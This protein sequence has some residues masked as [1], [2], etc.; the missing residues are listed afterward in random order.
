VTDLKSECFLLFYAPEFAL[1]RRSDQIA[2]ILDERVLVFLVSP[3]KA[4]I[5]KRLVSSFEDL[6]D[7]VNN[8]A[9]INAR[10]LLK[11]TGVRSVSEIASLDVLK[12][13]DQ[14]TFK[15]ASPV[16]IWRF[17]EVGTIVRLVEP[18]TP[19][20]A[21][22]AELKTGV[23][24]CC[25]KDDRKSRAHKSPTA[26]RFEFVIGCL[27]ESSTLQLHYCSSGCKLDKYG[28][29]YCENPPSP[30]KHVIDHKPKPKDAQKTEVQVGSFV[31][32]L[33]QK[34][35][36][37]P[38]RP[39][40]V[41]PPVEPSVKASKTDSGKRGRE[42]LNNDD[43]L[44]EEVKGRIATLKGLIEEL[45]AVVGQ[46]YS[47]ERL[48]EIRAV[49]NDTTVEDRLGDIAYW[50]RKLVEGEEMLP[51]QVVALIFDDGLRA[52]K[53]PP[54]DSKIFAW[55]VV[56]DREGVTGGPKPI[57]IGDPDAV[58]MNENAVLVVY[59]G[60][61]KVWVVENI[62]SGDVLFASE[63][64]DG[65]A[66]KDSV[67]GRV[68]VALTNSAPED[69]SVIA[70]VWLM[71]GGPAG[72][73]ELLALPKEVK[74]LSVYVSSQGE[75]ITLQAELLTEL[76]SRVE[77]LESEL[78]DIKIAVEENNE[79]V[80]ALEMRQDMTEQ[81]VDAHEDKIITVE[82]RLESQVVELEVLERGL[83]GVQHEVEKHDEVLHE[84]KVGLDDL[85]NNTHRR[86]DGHE[87]VITQILDVHEEKQKQVADSKLRL[88][89]WLKDT[90][91]LGLNDYEVKIIDG[92]LLQKKLELDT[93]KFIVL[94]NR[95]L[96]FLPQPVQPYLTPGTT[97]L[98]SGSTG[99]LVDLL[100][101]SGRH[102]FPLVWTF[103]L[104]NDN[105]RVDGIRVGRKTAQP[106]HV[107][108][109]RQQKK[110]VVFEGPLEESIAS[111]SKRLQLM[112]AAPKID[113]LLIDTFGGDNVE[114]ILNSVLPWMKNGTL[115]VFGS[116]LNF[117]N[118]D[119]DKMSWRSWL[120]F[121][122]KARIKSSYVSYY[123]SNLLLRVD[124]VPA[125]VQVSQ[126]SV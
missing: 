123:A 120:L 82:A 35:G 119:A 8:T 39:V 67:C 59:M 15:P 17:L 103:D 28:Y 48:A 65:K 4:D 45:G 104:W 81:V 105:G 14:I 11:F 75:A 60:H 34:G 85:A 38:P 111:F 94:K 25:L 112:R 27:N 106:Q 62:S 124:Q 19:N 93:D 22:L 88:E 43:S 54:T 24:R 100:E 71:Q 49:L 9:E 63:S 121:V 37:K 114:M 99:L 18:R 53:S 102:K 90:E 98:P 32:V 72:S 83:A 116:F 56:A 76:T 89:E 31:L 95:L 23:I 87:E 10:V 109:L 70:L 96:S 61:V 101:Q 12:H 42:G 64:N 52:T 36:V 44:V 117:A 2:D 33:L 115:I 118:W 84:V 107:E 78:E 77:I 108:Q 126:F 29:F 97:R 122:E 6:L 7:W 86:L 74:E 92:E 66:V 69:Q 91:T 46:F 51:G 58:K 73:P 55:T 13:G 47:A 110:L 50:T 5:D 1:F 125:V 113:L 80:I 16:D 57:L 21:M 68:G 30:P 79:K 26:C 40:I 41:A 20:A 3:S